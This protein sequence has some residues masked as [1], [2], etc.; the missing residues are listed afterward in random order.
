MKIVAYEPKYKDDFIEMNRAWIFALF[1]IE[2]EDER[3]LNNIESYIEKG[4]E[5][6][7]AIDDDGTIMA[8]CMVAPRGDGD[9]E[10]MKFTAKKEFAGKGAGS[11]CFRAC[12][13]Y[14]KERGV[15]KTVIV[16]SHKCSEAVHIYRKFGFQEIPL[17]RKRFAFERAD[18]VL[19]KTL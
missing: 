10:I 13:D 2:D 12:L 6:F 4:G 19:E 3:E 17:D 8:C 18:L 15:K 16:T 7:F 11:A 1:K 5:I 14:A 9:W